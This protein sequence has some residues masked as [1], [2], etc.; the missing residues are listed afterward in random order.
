MTPDWSPDPLG[1]ADVLPQPGWAVLDTAR[2]HRFTGEVILQTTPPVGVYFDAG[3][4]YLAERT[5]GPSL[6]ARLVDH[7]AL[8]AAQLERGIIR[9]GGVAHL[10]RLFER[11]PSIDRDAVLVTA[12]HLTAECVRWLAGQSV[13]AL[14]ATAYRYHPAG[15]QRW[16]DPGP[17][18]GSAGFRRWLDPGTAA[19][20]FPGDERSPD[21]EPYPSDPVVPS[22]PAVAVAHSPSS[23]AADGAVEPPDPGLREP[24]P[25]G[26][27][28]DH[29]AV[30]WPS[31]QIDTELIDTELIDTGLIDTGLIDT[32]LAAPELAAP[33]RADH[34]D[35]GS[36][37]PAVVD[38][39]AVTTA[40]PDPAPAGGSRVGAGVATDAGAGDAA[41]HDAGAD[42][43]DTQLA[44]RRAVASIGT[45][46]LAARR[47]L[48]S[49]SDGAAPAASDWSRG[50]TPAE[51]GGEPADRSVEPPPEP[52]GP[53]AG[54]S[55][56]R[57][58]PGGDTSSS[59]FDLTTSIT[60]GAADRPAEREPAERE[61]S[62]E[63]VGALRRLIDS[64]A[65][66]DS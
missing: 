22:V 46:S 18:D 33:E 43:T 57:L 38:D 36:P 53:P 10:G 61:P 23:A 21:P 17:A 13:T 44:I 26:G 32:G 20:A 4:I 12:E 8:S 58:R 27:P 1:V 25:A 9:V 19:G 55:R 37:R 6:G 49:S 30:I 11:V 28:S 54:P 65:R 31:G 35:A 45:G 63:R 51:P 14:R 66:H 2:R 52:A 34:G 29:F 24:A 64:L 7:G 3:R 47:R 39:P 60:L 40:A 62:T 56:Q 59:V 41:A 16:L 5:D 50:A 48:A 15:V 42:D